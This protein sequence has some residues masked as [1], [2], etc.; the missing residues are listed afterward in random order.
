[1]PIAAGARHAVIKD[2]RGTIPGP[3]THAPGGDGQVSIAIKL[4]N[5]SSGWLD[6]DRDGTLFGAESNMFGSSGFRVGG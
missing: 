2:S 1:L 6:V 4:D 5:G 3:V